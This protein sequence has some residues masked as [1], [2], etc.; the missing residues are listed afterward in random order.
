MNKDMFLLDQTQ[1]LVIYGASRNGIYYANFFVNQGF[2]IAY[3]IDK[4]ANEIGNRVS[5]DNGEVAVYSVEEA[6][7][8]H[9]EEFIVYI[10]VRNAQEQT[11]C[12]ELAR[13]QGYQKLIYL[14]LCKKT[15]DTAEGID[16]LMHI[17]NEIGAGRI[18]TDM[19]C[20]KQSYFREQEIYKDT[21]IIRRDREVVCYVP[22]DL[23]FYHNV[24]QIDRLSSIYGITRDRAIDIKYSDRPFSQM[25]F[26]KDCF[27]FFFNG[28]GDI[29]KYMDVVMRISNDLKQRS[30]PENQEWLDDRKHVVGTMVDK[31]YYEQNYWKNAAIPI[32]WNKKGFF[33]IQDGV[34]RYMTASML[35]MKKIP[36]RM[37]I[38]DY[39][40]W[41]NKK[42]LKKCL[43][44]LRQER[45]ES[46]PTP[47]SHPYFMECESECDSYGKTVLA[48]IQEYLTDIWEKGMSVL[49]LNPQI[50]Y[51][52]QNFA[53][54]GGN[55]T[56]VSTMEDTDYDLFRYF[57]E[58]M[59]LEKINISAD[60]GQR[61]YDITL[62]L[63]LWERMKDEMQWSEYMKEVDLRTK[64]ILI[65][66]SGVLPEYERQRILENT[67][68]SQY[69]SLRY[70]LEDKKIREVGVFTK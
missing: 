12:V 67:R 60:M 53:R 48:T 33:N 43:D 46:F 7:T 11:K 70:V 17:Y 14:P 32:V 16:A 31:T 61:E 27:S 62:G 65:W 19:P 42:S 29:Q 1:W 13:K 20:P 63:K 24:E 22:L 3:F 54:M 69:H 15:N 64:N 5:L 35:Y 8:E 30:S 18:V 50:G 37:T 34:H 6:P 68:F 56:A 2:K 10:A 66:E 25:D 59:Y 28:T 52:S 58:L 36:T 39:E 23:I 26:Y 47:V 55:V 9:R 40:T 21:A 38:E 45:I 41:V 49:D 4:K 57:N 51:F 44:Y